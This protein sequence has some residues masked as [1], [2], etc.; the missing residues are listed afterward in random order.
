MYYEENR[1]IWFKQLALI[2][3]VLT[4]FILRFDP[5]EPC[6]HFIWKKKEKE[7][8][9]ADYTWYAIL[10]RRK[11][12]SSIE[13]DSYFRPSGSFPF[14][15]ICVSCIER[16]ALSGHSGWGK[17]YSE[18]WNGNEHVRLLLCIIN[19]KVKCDRSSMIEQTL[20]RTMTNCDFFSKRQNKV[21]PTFSQLKSN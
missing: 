15:L 17:F 14:V 5:I 21:L 20:P 10:R 12:C 8:P 11:F 1:L 9:F 13:S 18:L 3:L 4:L 16:I 2:L 6:S 19:G 7:R